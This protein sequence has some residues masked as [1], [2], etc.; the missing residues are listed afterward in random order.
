MSRLDDASYVQLPRRQCCIGQ[1]AAALISIAMFSMQPPN[2]PQQHKLRWY[3]IFV[4]FCA[5]PMLFFLAATLARKQPGSEVDQESL[6]LSIELLSLGW[7]ATYSIAF[8]PRLA[9]GQLFERFHVVSIT[10]LAFSEVGGLFAFVRAVSG[11]PLYF[12]WLILAPIAINLLL[13]LPPARRYWDSS[14]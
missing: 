10:A 11:G 7:G 5:A 9:R 12:R 6:W 4:A 1:G 8:F 3:V 13:I 14:G 2:T